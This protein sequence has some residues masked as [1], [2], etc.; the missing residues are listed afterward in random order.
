MITDEIR[1]WDLTLKQYCAS[2]ANC[3]AKKES[4]GI[5][6]CADSWKKLIW[7]TK[8][9]SILDCYN[10]ISEINEVEPIVL[11]TDTPCLNDDDIR[12]LFGQAS[13]IINSKPC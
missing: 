1:Y 5:D 4:F 8:I 6:V 11:N 10:V 2:F 7:A 9:I 12:K 3:M 13:K